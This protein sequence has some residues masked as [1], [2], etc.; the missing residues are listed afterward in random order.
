MRRQTPFNEPLSGNALDSIPIEEAIR[1][2]TSQFANRTVLMVHRANYE[3]G[4]FE[5]KR[6]TQLFARTWELVSHN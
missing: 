3:G 5:S 2:I 1:N 4:N 6:H